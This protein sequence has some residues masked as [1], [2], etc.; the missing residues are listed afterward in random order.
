MIWKCFVLLTEQKSV[1]YV[2]SGGINIVTMAGQKKHSVHASILLVLLVGLVT[3]A[4]AGTL[5]YD[6]DDLPPRKISSVDQRLQIDDWER[7][8]E[9]FGIGVG[10]WFIS[11]EDG[12]V[13]IMDGG[14]GIGS[15]TGIYHTGDWTDYEV[16]GRFQLRSLGPGGVRLYV[17]ATPLRPGMFYFRG[18]CYRIWSK[19]PVDIGVWYDVRIVAEGNRVTYFLDGKKVGGETAAEMSGGVAFTAEMSELWLDYIE[20]TGV[21]PVQPQ[22]RLATCWAKLKRSHRHQLKDLVDDSLSHRDS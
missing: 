22:G 18:N 19:N 12:F 9:C 21:L 4:Y 15:I 14:C 1:K 20:I 17:R 6:F 7:H 10:P 3:P 13:K 11:V 2:K 16:K 5:W 8:R